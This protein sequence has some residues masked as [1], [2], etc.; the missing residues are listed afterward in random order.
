MF[1]ICCVGYREYR[2]IPIGKYM[3]YTCIVVLLHKSSYKKYIYINIGTCL[4]KLQFGLCT[5]LYC[6]YLL[7]VTDVNYFDHL[8]VHPILFIFS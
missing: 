4:E 8:Q 7:Y 1:I 6:N 5:K 2:I 3:L